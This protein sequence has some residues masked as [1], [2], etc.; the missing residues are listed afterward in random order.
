MPTLLDTPQTALQT[1]TPSATQPAA[2][3]PQPEAHD[4]GLYRSG[5]AAHLAG[6]PVQTLRVWERRYGLTQTERSARGQRLYSPR[7]VERLGLIKQLVDYGHPVGLLAR[8]SVERLQEMRAPRHTASAAIRT[9]SLR[10]A[11]VGPSLTMRLSSDLRGSP[12]MPACDIVRVCDSMK[13]AGENLQDARADIVLIEVAELSDDL[14]PQIQA[15]RQAAQARAAVVLYHFSASSTLEHLRLQHCL[16]AREPVPPADVIR[17]CISSLDNDASAPPRQQPVSAWQ[18][19]PERRF[20]DADLAAI[21]TAANSVEC[22]CPRHLAD[23]LQIIG[24]FERFS[25]QCASRNEKDAQLHQDLAHI[26]G[27][28]RAL[29][30]VAMDTLARAEGLPLPPMTETTEKPAQ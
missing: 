8:L 17:M 25:Q 7:Q 26:S 2:P 28:A 11:L 30:E 19:A 16:L 22:G 18:E 10:I 20:S 1:A 13:D 3:E 9:R 6:I 15:I 24:S 5:T 12:G 21:S 23:I 4:A 27:Q 14:L 29:L